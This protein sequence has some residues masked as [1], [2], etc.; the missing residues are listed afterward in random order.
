MFANVQKWGNSLGLRI[1]KPLAEE[2]RIVEG[3][4]VELAVR[5]DVLCV[6]PVTPRRYSLEE[7]VAQ[8]SPENIHGEVDFGPAVG[9]ELW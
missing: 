6:T 3:S 2:A 1:P 5:N 8:I 9:N 4:L 7:L